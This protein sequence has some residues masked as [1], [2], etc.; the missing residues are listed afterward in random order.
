M[1]TK[2]KTGWAGRDTGLRGSDWKHVKSVSELEHAYAEAKRNRA[3]LGEALAK[4]HG[5]KK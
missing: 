3:N 4:A 5:T 2:K 1:A